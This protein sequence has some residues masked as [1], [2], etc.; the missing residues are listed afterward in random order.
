MTPPLLYIR[1][2]D[3]R[4]LPHIDLR[5]KGS[6]PSPLLSTATAFLAECV[7]AVDPEVVIEYLRDIFTED[8]VYDTLVTTFNVLTVLLPVLNDPALANELGPLVVVAFKSK[9]EIIAILRNFL[10]GCLD[11]DT[12]QERDL[13]NWIIVTAGSDTNYR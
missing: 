7:I 10:N 5:T 11:L 4:L 2:V 12:S 3:P 1:A 8:V 9:V 13:S 6:W